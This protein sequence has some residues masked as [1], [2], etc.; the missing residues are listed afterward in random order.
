M[1][2]L[3]K[4]ILGLLL[5]VFM[6]ALYSYGAN[7]QVTQIKPLDKESL[8]WMFEQCFEKRNK[9]EEREAKEDE[10]YLCLS[11]E[12]ISELASTTVDVSFDRIRKEYLKKPKCLASLLQQYITIIWDYL[13]KEMLN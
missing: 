10:Y 5:I 1:K 12:K 9:R 11:M 7:D 6:Q 2:N 8:Q 3:S 13:K 4:F